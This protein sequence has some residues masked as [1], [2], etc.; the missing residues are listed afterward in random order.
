M[1]K[2]TFSPIDTLSRLMASICYFSVL[3]MPVVLPLI[4][5]LVARLMSN[6]NEAVAYHAKRAFWS[7]VIPA[8]FGIFALLL[9]TGIGFSTDFNS[10]ALSG[11][12]MALLIL[13]GLIA[14]GLWVYNI[15]MAILV[16]LDR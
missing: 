10:W 8:I 5:W 4:A 12:S 15:V 1:M 6:P 14:A 9:I 16:L 3:F 13:A 2:P 7:Q 11:L